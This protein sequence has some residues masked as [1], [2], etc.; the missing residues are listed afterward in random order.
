[1]GVVPQ[2]RCSRWGGSLCGTPEYNEVLHAAWPHWMKDRAPLSWGTCR[3]A[4]LSAKKSTPCQA[5]PLLAVASAWPS[6]A[7][8][9]RSRLTRTTADMFHKGLRLE[10]NSAL[11]HVHKIALGRMNRSGVGQASTSKVRTRLLLVSRDGTG[12]CSSMRQKMKRHALSAVGLVLTGLFATGALAAKALT[13][14]A[15]LEMGATHIIVGKVRSISFTKNV[16]S[17]WVTTAYVAEIAID[18]IEKGEGLRVGDVV[19]ARYLTRG[20]RGIGTPPPHD[21]GHNP[22]PNNN[23]S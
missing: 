1:M 23:D 11:S 14:K 22:K 9:I 15:R 5:Q 8:R 21:S 16:E 7:N 20:W 3:E 6:I 2:R 17:A 19:R 12:K 18:K 10:V 13:S 4:A